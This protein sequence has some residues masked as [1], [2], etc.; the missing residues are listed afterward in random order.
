VRGA[1]VFSSAARW[2]KSAKTL[3]HCSVY[4]GVPAAIDTRFVRR[5]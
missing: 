3:L 1:L 4:A 5:K 2:Q